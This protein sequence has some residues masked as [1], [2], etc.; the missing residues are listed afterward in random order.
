MRKNTFQKS[1]WK[2]SAIQILLFCMVLSCAFFTQSVT[3]NAASQ[4]TK[5]LKE[6]QRLLSQKKLKWNSR[7][8]V[9]S[10]KLKFS[11][12]YVDKDSVPELFID[13]TA[14]G[15]GHV[16]G[17]YKLYTYRNGKLYDVGTYRDSF[18]YYKK[19]GVFVTKTYLHGE[20]QAYHKLAKGTDHIKLRSEKY[21]TTQCFDEN[22][23]TISKAAFKKQ[24]KK[25]TRKKKVSVPVCYKNT[26]ANRTKQLQ[27]WK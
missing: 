14:A 25:L 20:Y 13:G 22:G 4:K 19:T 12:I 27:K 7:Q 18:G 6:Y 17:G 15:T 16:S 2:R 9:R 5:A 23:N 26:A 21:Y 8:K 3:S 24:V 11:L 10:S 1:G